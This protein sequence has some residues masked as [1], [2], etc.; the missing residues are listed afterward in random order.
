MLPTLMVAIG[1]SYMVHVINQIGISAR[2][3]G[4]GEWGVGSGGSGIGNRESGNMS[5]SPFPTPHSPFPTPRSAIEEALRF[6]SLPVIV[7]ALTIIAGFLSLAFTEIPAI[8]STAIYS[9]IGAAFTMIL[10]LTFI[11]AALT[12]MGGRAIRFRVGLA[13]GM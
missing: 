8:R 12:L 13:G 7:S 6:I 9:A 4:S 1:C 5:D 11:P 2:R 3:V 10:S